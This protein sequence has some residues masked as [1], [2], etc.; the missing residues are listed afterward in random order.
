M[1][2]MTK[3][4][5]NRFEPREATDLDGRYGEIGISAV[6]AAAQWGREREKRSGSQPA[7][8]FWGHLVG[9]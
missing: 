7:V 2:I 9:V 8:A 4:D 6:V 3:P 1:Q 5:A